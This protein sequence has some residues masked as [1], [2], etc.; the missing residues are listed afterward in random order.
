MLLE[1]LRI[2]VYT[3]LAGAV[4][5]SMASTLGLLFIPS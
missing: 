4:D 1:S 2:N 3:K 5:T